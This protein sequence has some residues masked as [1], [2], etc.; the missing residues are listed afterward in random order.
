MD[1]LEVGEGEEEGEGERQSG[2]RSYFEERI[3]KTKKAMPAD[4]T[5]DIVEEDEKQEIVVME[6]EEIKQ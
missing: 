5:A 1:D 2:V 6:K 3:C 4:F